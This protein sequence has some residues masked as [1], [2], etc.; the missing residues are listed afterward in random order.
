[1]AAGSAQPLRLFLD[2]GVILQGC[3]GRWGA[4][5]GVLI[6]ATERRLYT[7]VQTGRPDHAPDSLRPR[8]CRTQVLPSGSWK[9]AN[10]W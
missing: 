6:L 9:S 3:F 10:D 8:S 7:V 1:M 4:S 2:T 5:K